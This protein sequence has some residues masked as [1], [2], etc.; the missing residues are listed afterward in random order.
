MT[1]RTLT[2]PRE[3]LL[4]AW[5]AAVRGYRAARPVGQDHHG[6]HDKAVA[7]VRKLLPDVSEKEAA[8][9]VIEAVAFAATYHAEWFWRG[10]RGWERNGRRRSPNLRRPLSFGDGA[11]APPR[12]A[13]ISHLTAGAT[14][15]SPRKGKR[16][17][18]GNIPTARRCAHALID[19]TPTLMRPC[20]GV[21]H[22]ELSGQRP[23]RML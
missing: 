11:R 19:A 2:L 20:G 23:V 7:A 21:F 4:P 16:A 17:V 5:R 6:A 12:C 15:A 8:Q 18:R 22:R 9:E 13:A 3:Q 1:Q 10:V 14:T